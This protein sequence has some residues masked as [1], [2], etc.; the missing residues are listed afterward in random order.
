MNITP[1]D[2]QVNI[3]NSLLPK[4]PFSML[5]CGSKASGKSTTLINLIEKGLNNT[6]NRIILISPTHAYDDKLQH[7][8]NSPVQKPNWALYKKMNTQFLWDKTKKY[9]KDEFDKKYSYIDTN[10]IHNHLNLDILD[11]LI[12]D[13]D[14]IIKT[15]GKNISDKVLLI[16]DDAIQ[17]D[18]IKSRKFLHTNLISRHLNISIIF[19]TQA[20]YLLPKSL[21]LNTTTLCLFKIPNEKELKNIQEEWN[22]GIPKE[23][24]FAE[25][26]RLTNIPFN[27]VVLNCQNQIGYR[28][29]NAFKEFIL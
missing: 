20:Y 5:L 1:L 11:D 3:T 7:L 18:I 14:Y 13:Q 10:D 12:E 24:F 16:L 17:S 25:Y 4:H 21:R 26:E 8:I 22:I 23:K 27:F 19:V 2:K 9:D 29:Q 6:F 28:F 15:Y